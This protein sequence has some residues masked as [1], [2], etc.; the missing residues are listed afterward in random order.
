MSLTINTLYINIL[1]YTMKHLK[2]QLYFGLT[3]LAVVIAGFSL[4]AQKNL[5]MSVYHI[6]AGSTH[7]HTAYTWSH[8]SQYDDAK[9]GG[10]LIDSQNV[11]HPK[12]RTPKADWQKY[13][14]FPPDHYAAAKANG[15]DFY[16]T[17]D[18]SQ[19]AA[20]HPT[21]PINEAWLAT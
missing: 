18:H 10:I 6:Y 5:P 19:E 13:Q 2:A 8:G 3:T 7:A 1:S 16:V 9:E 12:N 20:F 14:G 17:T 15:Y 4:N 21:N 11:A